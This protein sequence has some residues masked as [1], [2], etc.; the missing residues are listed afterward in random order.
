VSGDLQ[1]GGTTSAEAHWIP[2]SDLMTGLMVIFMLIAISY[3]VVAERT[4]GE[5]KKMA[6]SYVDLRRQIYSALNEEFEDDL[7]SW[8]AEIDPDDL[9]VRFKNPKVLFAENSAVLQPDFTR[10]L[11]EFFPKYVR[12]LSQEEF[13][14]S[15]AEV[16]IEGHT[17]SVWDS[18]STPEAAYFQNMRLSQDRTRSVL[19]Y[20]FLLPQVADERTWLR[21]RVTANGLSSSH[22]VYMNDGKTEDEDRSRRVEFRVRTST[23]ALVEEIEKVAE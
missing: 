1:A 14:G 12:I 7:A 6:A 5:M 8:G 10:I 20:V 3:M 4:T 13:R 9:I 16:R 21:E 19:E 2:L 23:E 17:S 22:L 15:I 11:S 18:F